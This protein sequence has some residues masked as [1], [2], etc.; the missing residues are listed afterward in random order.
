MLS[1][2]IVKCVVICNKFAI[3]LAQ[4]RSCCKLQLC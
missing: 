1:N 4:W 3:V 2:K